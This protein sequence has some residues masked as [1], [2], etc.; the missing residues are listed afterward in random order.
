MKAMYILIL[1][2]LQGKFDIDAN[3]RQ[4]VF[5]TIAGIGSRIKESPL[6]PQFSW[7]RSNIEVGWIMSILV[8]LGQF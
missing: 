7:E 3:E 1:W 6:P 4:S 5:Q 2:S 8:P